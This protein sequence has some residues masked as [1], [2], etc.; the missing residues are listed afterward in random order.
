M[1][2]NPVICFKGIRLVGQVSD[3][4]ELVGHKSTASTERY[5]LLCGEETLETGKSVSKRLYG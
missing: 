2:S 3:C 4:E 1:W 5:S